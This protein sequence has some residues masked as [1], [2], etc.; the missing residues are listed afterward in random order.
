VREPEVFARPA[1]VA[2]ALAGS[3]VALTVAVLARDPLPGETRVLEA[4]HADPGSR[5]AH[6][7]QAVSDATDLL[8]LA[9][10]AVVGL[11]VLVTLRRRGDAALL[12]AALL[13]VAAVNPLLKLVVQRDR[14]DLLAATADVSRYGYPSGHAAHTLALVAGALAVLLP[15]LG[16]RGRTVAV[17]VGVLLLAVVAAAQLALARHYPSDLLAGWLVAGAWAALL[18]AGRAAAERLDAA[19]AHSA[20]RG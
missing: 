16:R 2:A 13:V 11:A 9:V 3:F 6:A 10:V 20:N 17:G 18:V 1:V 8:P 12:A 14:P 19:R 7:W 15:G 5:A 4:V